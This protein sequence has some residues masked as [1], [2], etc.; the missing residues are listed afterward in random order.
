MGINRELDLHFTRRQL[1]GLSARGIGIGALA[2]L[3]GPEVLTAAQD[4]AP[5]S[6]DPK[7]GGL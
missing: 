7:T 5:P 3:L 1:F 6:R 2:S 4:A